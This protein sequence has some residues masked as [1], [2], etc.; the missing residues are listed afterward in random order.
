MAKTWIAF[1]R[2]INVGGNSIL[3]MKSLVSLIKSLGGDDVRTYIQSGNA[4]FRH[5][6]RDAGKLAHRI[7]SAVLKAHG[8]TPNV[9]LLTRMEMENAANANP[10]SEAVSAPKT[11][12][13]A[14][15]GAPPVN[16][17]IDGLKACARSDEAFQIIG[18][19]FYL[20]TPAGIGQSKLA[21]RYEKLLGVR[22]TA[23][24]WNTVLKVLEISA[25]LKK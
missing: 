2:G 9:L 23:R 17:D 14:F 10:F 4:V 7:E 21:A 3:L 11:L 5:T 15:L 16:A 12:H 6:E 20:H 25:L 8:F 22:A 13:I 18:N 1:F 24:N 19:V